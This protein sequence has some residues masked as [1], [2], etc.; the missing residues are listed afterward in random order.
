MIELCDLKGYLVG[1]N[2]AQV[3]RQTGVKYHTL[4][5]IVNGIPR[6]FYDPRYSDVKRL[7]NF[8]ISKGHI[9]A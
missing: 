9:P 8:L 4:C 5:K 6:G 2:L 7:E 3:S 1:Y